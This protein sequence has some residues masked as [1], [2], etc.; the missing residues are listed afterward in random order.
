MGSEAISWS[1][2]VETFHSSAMKN[3]EINI[4]IASTTNINVNVNVTNDNLNDHHE[5]KPCLHKTTRLTVTTGSSWVQLHE[6]V[7]DSGAVASAAD[8]RFLQSTAMPL[9]DLKVCRP[10]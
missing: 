9:L 3:N 7:V 4:C 5:G 8:V 2:N 6:A 10:W 1:S